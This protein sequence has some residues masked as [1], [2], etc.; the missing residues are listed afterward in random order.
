MG[1]GFWSTRDK[2]V[3]EHTGWERGSGAHGIKGFWST[4]DKGVLEH[5]G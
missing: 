3:L 5:T 1:K 2:G 4:R